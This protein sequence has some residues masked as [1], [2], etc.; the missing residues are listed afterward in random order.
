MSWLTDYDTDVIYSGHHQQQPI[1]GM[2]KL[3]ARGGN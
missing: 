2:E 3:S 1:M